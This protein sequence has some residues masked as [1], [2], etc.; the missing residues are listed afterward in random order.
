M[1]RL[2]PPSPALPLSGAGS[3]WERLQPDAESLNAESWQEQGA[4]L[5]I[6]G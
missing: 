3:C 2:A 4:A 1:Q 5:G 6:F